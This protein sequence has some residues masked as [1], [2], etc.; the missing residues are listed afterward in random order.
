MAANARSIA[1]RLLADWERTRPHAD[2][3]L[4]E[5]LAASRIDTRDRALVTELFYG[6]LRHLSE[7]DF[8]IGRLRNG[9]IDDDTRA[10]LRLGLYQLFHTRIATFAAVKETVSTGFLK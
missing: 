4:H 8:F 6:V 9:E 5:R 1:H 2:D 3:I 10:V 7:L